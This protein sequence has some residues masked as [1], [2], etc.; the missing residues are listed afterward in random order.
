LEKLNDG[1]LPAE[2]DAPGDN[3][4]FTAGTAGGRLQLDL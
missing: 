3:F 2:E 1:L 4:F